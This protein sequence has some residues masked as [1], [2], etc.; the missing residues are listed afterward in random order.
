MTMRSQP[1]CL[2]V[3]A[4]TN[5]VA[6]NRWRKGLNGMFKTYPVSSRSHLEKALLTLKP[7]VVLVDL[8][9]PQLNGIKGMMAIQRLSSMT[10]ILLLT[11]TTEESVRLLALKEGARG[12]CD[13]D[14][15]PTMMRQAVQ[16]VQKG[17][18]WA[19]R[20]I[21]AAL[22]QDLI[23][24]THDKEFVSLTQQREEKHPT[25]HGTL[26]DLT[27]RER[28][29]VSLIGRAASNKEIANTLQISESTVKA[30][31]GSIFRKLGV[32]GRLALALLISGVSNI[33]TEILSTTN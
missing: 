6:Q 18:I 8:N 26:D 9:L 33:P 12:Y 19:E 11:T 4:S 22:L 28:E 32:S 20:R 7:S 23:S 16:M 14:L 15:D 30:H 21:I 10:K 5:R 25:N 13:L 31:V 27:S 3:I 1:S 24:R 29:I 17:E 2:V